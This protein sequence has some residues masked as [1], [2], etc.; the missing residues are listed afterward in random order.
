M[1]HFVNDVNEAT[2]WG[3]LM[4]VLVSHRPNNSDISRRS[5]AWMKTI[6]VK[7]VERRFAYLWVSDPHRLPRQALRVMGPFCGVNIRESTDEALFTKLSVEYE[8]RI[9]KPTQLWNKTKDCKYVIPKKGSL[10]TEEGAQ[11]L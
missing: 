2:S 9:D 10:K 6:H 8:E 3:G 5:Q 11:L 1:E 4:D 7:S